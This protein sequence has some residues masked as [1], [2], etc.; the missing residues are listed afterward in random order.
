MGNKLRSYSNSR[1]N[2]TQQ[3]VDMVKSLPPQHVYINAVMLLKEIIREEYQRTNKCQ[4]SII[5][6]ESAVGQNRGIGWVLAKN[7][8]YLEEFNY[9]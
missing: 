9:G 1:C 3:C 7:S 4:L 8:P 6:G 5:R 2:L